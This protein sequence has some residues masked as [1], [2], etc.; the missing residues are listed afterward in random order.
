PHALIVRPCVHSQS[1]KLCSSEIQTRQ[2]DVYRVVG[3]LEHCRFRCGRADH[4][5]SVSMK[6]DL[7]PP[8]PATRASPRK[9]AP[10]PRNE[11]S[12]SV[13]PFQPAPPPPLQASPPPAPSTQTP[14]NEKASKRA[15]A[16]ESTGRSTP[17]PFWVARRE[18]RTFVYFALLGLGLLITWRVSS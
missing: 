17:P 13:T 6:I 11:A 2:A 15:E 4:I 9:V 3:S 16:G 14:S 7:P 10:T 18:A 8:I 1:S 12:P 5:T